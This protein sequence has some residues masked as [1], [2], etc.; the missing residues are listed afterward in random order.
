[1]SAPTDDWREVPP[2]A[3]MPLDWRDLAPGRT[4]SL[5]DRMAE[6][7]GADHVQLTC[8]GTA[9]LVIALT[10]LH[11]LS[12]RRSVIVPAYTCPLVALA[13]LHCGLRLRVCD[14]RPGGFDLEPA[15]LSRLC[16][17]DTLAVLPTHLAGRV[18][19]VESACISARATGAFVIEDAAQALG[20]RRGERS[21][22]LLGDVGFFSL[23][24]GKGLTTYEGG[25]LVATDAAVRTALRDTAARIAPPRVARELQRML[26]LC[27]YWM[28]Y[29]PRPL[30]LAYGW[31]LR[32]ALRRGDPVAAVG[33]DFDADDFQASIPLHALGGWRQAVGARALPRLH[34]FQHSLSAQ[35][36]LR[37]PRLLALP[38]VDVLRDNPDTCGVWPFFLLLMPTR[39]AR[40]AALQRLWTAGLGVSRLF[41]HALPDYA[42][43]S[44]KIIAADIPN[45]RDLAA[46]SLTV[47]N[48]LW[49]SDA[50]FE[51]ICAE[52]AAAAARYPA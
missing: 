50:Q 3:G 9:A 22:G 4:P 24:A 27:G 6:F 21:V 14:V 47:S 29:R 23:A 18:A 43:L 10:A 17:A 35:A 49:L 39:E 1:M 8:S 28:L 20:A 36:R 45:A 13:V 7:I 16:D 5:H 26:Q 32:R 38:G 52:L 46:R 31:P 34:A 41:I 12:G 51:A 48:S 11:G 25:V 44:T 30:R 19:D 40:D 2:T 15:H 33:D 42:Y 37:L